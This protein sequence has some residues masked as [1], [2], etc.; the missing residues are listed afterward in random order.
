MTMLDSEKI[1]LINQMLK[2]FWDFG[3]DTREN[4]LCM[5]NAIATVVDFKR[6]GKE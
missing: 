2:D 4:A 1:E 6:N 3:Y 5:L